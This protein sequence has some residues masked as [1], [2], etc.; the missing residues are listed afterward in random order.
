M[1]VQNILNGETYTV[2][3]DEHASQF[4]ASQLVFGSLVPWDGAWYWSGM[5]RGFDTVTLE[6]MAQVKQ[7]FY[8]KAPQIVYRYCG[9]LA[10]QAREILSKHYQQ[11]MDYFGKD[12]VIY[13]HGHALADDMRKFHQ[14]QFDSAPKKE[15]E[16]LLKKH[17]L[18]KPSPKIEL[19]PDILECDDGIGVYFN[20]DEG[21]EM[22][23]SFDDVISGFQKQ[24]NGLNEDESE[25]IRQL[26]YSDAIS[27]QFVRKLVQ[28]YGDASIASAF[29]IP[30]DYDKHYLEYLLRRYKGHFYRK[31]YPSLTI[32]NT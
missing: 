29:L 13:H 2:R 7:D 14:Y 28:Q 22:M 31:R 15:V 6:I 21:Q 18:A 27:P 25:M 26:L 12:L 11:F 24:G 4:R 30:Q 3:V 1:E 16:A 8:L 10:A 5:Q 19:P 9:N 32:V 20:R 23:T 17:H